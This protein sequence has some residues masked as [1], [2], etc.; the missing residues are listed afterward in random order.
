[1][2]V[3]TWTKV[4]DPSAIE[5]CGRLGPRQVDRTQP[6]DE[7]IAHGAGRHDRVRVGRVGAA[8]VADVAGRRIRRRSSS[9]E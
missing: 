6:G 5:C 4:F 9:S 3:N 1:V 2:V 8:D 7:L